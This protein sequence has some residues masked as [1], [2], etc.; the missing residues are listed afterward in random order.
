MSCSQPIFVNVQQW[1]WQK[2]NREYI[3]EPSDSMLVGSYVDAWLD[4]KIDEFKEINPQ[5][6]TKRRIKITI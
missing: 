1:L 6:Y 4:G 2:L 5:I 3:T